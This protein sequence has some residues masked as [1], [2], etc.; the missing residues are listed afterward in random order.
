MK[1]YFSVSETARALDVTE[2]TVWNYIKKGELRTVRKKYRK[3]G[4]ERI[5]IELLSLEKC[6]IRKKYP[7][8]YGTRDYMVR[9][10]EEQYNKQLELKIAFQEVGIMAEK[11]ILDGLDYF[12]GFDEAELDQIIENGT[13]LWN[14]WDVAAYM[15]VSLRTVKRYISKGKLKPE[16]MTE[17]GEKLF[18][19]LD[20]M[21]LY[22]ENKGCQPVCSE[23]EDKEAIYTFIEEHPECIPVFKTVMDSLLQ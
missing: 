20:V 23:E 13:E 8:I 21:E 11:D 1:H 10:F 22:R 9:Y 17:S 14:I 16:K 15:E 3:T 7:A 12:S 4:R 5:W 19:N 2:R 18:S 6:L